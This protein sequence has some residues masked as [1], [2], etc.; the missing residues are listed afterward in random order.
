MPNGCQPVCVALLPCFLQDCSVA[1]FRAVIPPQSA[2]PAP[3]S[4]C[5]LSCAGY[6]DSYFARL[7][8]PADVIAAI[9]SHLRSD[10][11]YH[12]VDQR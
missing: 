4:K 10:D 1:G 9:L 2:H 5:S 11:L 8:L 3:A 12:Q 6:P 7:P